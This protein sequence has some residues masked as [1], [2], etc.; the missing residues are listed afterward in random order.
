MNTLQQVLN[1]YRSKGGEKAWTKET[2]ARN[3]HNINLDPTGS[4]ATQWCLYGA[5][6][7][8]HP[9]IIAKIKPEKS[10]VQEMERR[11]NQNIVSWNDSPNTTWMDVKSMLS[12]EDEPI[13]DLI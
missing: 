3:T 4:L 9:S 13:E 1:F 7:K 5:L 11:I 6:C 10:F 12:Q 8:V 2:I